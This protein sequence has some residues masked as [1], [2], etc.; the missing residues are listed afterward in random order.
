[1][2]LSSIPLLFGRL[3]LA[4]RFEAYPSVTVFKITLHNRYEIVI[5]SPL[6]TVITES[7]QK[8]R[9]RRRIKVE[10]FT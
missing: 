7:K 2:D 6:L 4:T 9:L 10:T 3:Y 8:C 5:V 1:M